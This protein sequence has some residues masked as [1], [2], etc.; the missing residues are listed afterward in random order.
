MDTAWLGIG[1]IEGFIIG[2][3]VSLRGQILVKGDD[4]SHQIL[5]EI[6]NILALFFASSKLFPSFKKIFKGD[7]ML[8]LMIQSNSHKSDF[9][10]PRTFATS[11]KS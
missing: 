8:I 6:L 2:V 11:G 5:L 7:D 4:V 10:P 3:F 9:T 1:D